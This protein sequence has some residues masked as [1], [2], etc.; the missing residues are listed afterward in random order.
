MTAEDFN[1]LDELRNDLFT[2]RERLSGLKS[3]SAVSAV[4][5]S[6]TGGNDGT[7]DSVANTAV[8]IVDIEN[9]ILRCVLAMV[10]IIDTV[11]KAYT[12]KVMRLRYV[13]SLSWNQIA[14]RLGYTDSAAPYRLLRR[15]RNRIMSKQPRNDNGM[16]MRNGVK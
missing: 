1:K 10:E 5:Y 13:N 7:G 6:G 4:N 3:A 14:Q 15:Y 11:P 16:T 12:R 9:A 2:L 8:K